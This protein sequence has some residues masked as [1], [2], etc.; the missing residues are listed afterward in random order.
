MNS[1]GEDKEERRRKMS[2]KDKKEEGVVMKHE[3]KLRK[4]TF[5][6]SKKQPTMK[7]HIA[8]FQKFANGDDCVFGS[9][10]CSTHNT[11]LVRIVVK[12]R[13][14]SVSEEERVTLP[15]GEAINLAC[16]Y[17]IDKR[18]VGENKAVMSESSRFEGTNEN[19]RICLDS[20]TDQPHA[21][22]AE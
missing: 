22:P 8:I 14:C 6:V 7:E 1:N 20:E 2:I 17:R 13:V 15:M 10:R 12:K 9:G 19:K 5:D 21:S 11:K 16:P 18:S 3:E 4:T